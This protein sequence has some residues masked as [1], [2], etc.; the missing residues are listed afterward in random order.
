MSIEKS[1][2]NYLKQ[3]ELSY[4]VL[5]NETINLIKDGF[6]LGI[7]TYLSS[8]PAGWNICKK[9]LMNHFDV[10]RDFINARFKYLQSLNLLQITAVKDKSGKIKYWET[11]LKRRTNIQN[12]EKPYCGETRILKNQILAEPDSG[13]SAPINK[14]NNKKEK[15]DINPF[16]F[17][18]EGETFTSPENGT[19]KNNINQVTKEKSSLDPTYEYPDT[20]Y[21]KPEISRH[22]KQKQPLS[23]KLSNFEMENPYEIPVQMIM[24]WKVSRD[25]KKKPVTKTAW[26]KILKELEKCKIQ[27]IN[28]IDAFEEMV[29]QGWTSLKSEYFNKSANVASKAGFRAQGTLDNRKLSLKNGLY[30]KLD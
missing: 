8:K 7:Y 13:E 10:G 12:T 3:E 1:T 22:S 5:I 28:P 11:L 15:N 9:E 27:G 19:G 2:P 16:V 21:P 17:P 23:S 20:L 6:A 25:K 30:S 14:R 24:D 18:Q 26:N 29:C 4:T